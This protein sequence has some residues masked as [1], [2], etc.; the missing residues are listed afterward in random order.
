MV[1]SDQTLELEHGFVF[2]APFVGQKYGGAARP[3]Q[4]VG[5]YHGSVVTGIPVRSEGLR[6]DNNGVGVLV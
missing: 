6:G 3:E 4:T 1:G 2:Q 5:Q